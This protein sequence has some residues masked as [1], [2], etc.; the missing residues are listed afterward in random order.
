MIS[1]EDESRWLSRLQGGE[2]ARG[3]AIEELRE[4]I[5]RGLS[6]SL[7]HRYGRILQAEDV[8]QDALLKI[9]ASLDSFEGRSKFTTWAMTIATRVGITALRRKHTKDISLDSLGAADSMK[10]ELA[11]EGGP[12][13]EQQL[14]QR[15]VIEQLNQLIEEVLSPKQRLAIRGLLEGV[16]IE[17][18]AEKTGS[19]RNAVYKL[20]HDARSKLK[21]G[22]AT[23]G[24]GPD[25]VLQAIA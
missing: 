11:V 21:N 6:K 14:E 12:S 23:L 13:S 19:N 22:F 15:G 4:I 2:P 24:M 17:Q 9:L 1:A 16:P 10:I 5:L 7:N 20:V 18:I 25:D 3:E 8:V